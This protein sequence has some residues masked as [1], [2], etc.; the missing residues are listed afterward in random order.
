MSQVGR[1]RSFNKIFRSFSS[2]DALVIWAVSSL[3]VFKSSI[4][5]Y[6][7][8]WYQQVGESHTK[9]ESLIALQTLG[10][11]NTSDPR[12]LTDNIW[13]EIRE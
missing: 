1:T 3:R 5:H 6:S 2:A 10:S 8:V 9:S 11:A 13:L 7:E 4:S 12:E